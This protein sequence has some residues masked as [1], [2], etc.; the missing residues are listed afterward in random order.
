MSKTKKRRQTAYRGFTL[1][2]D[3]PGSFIKVSL[4]ANPDCYFIALSY[5]SAMAQINTMWAE[6]PDDVETAFGVLA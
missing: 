4:E 1:T 2:P 5:S 3:P 6:F